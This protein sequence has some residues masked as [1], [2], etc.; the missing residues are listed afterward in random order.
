[1][2]P[3]ILEENK[4][5]VLIAELATGHVFKKDLTLFLNGR[6]ENDVFQVFETIQSAKNF[7]LDFIAKAP[8]FECS[9]FDNRREPL[10]TFDKHGERN[11]T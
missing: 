7:A 11:I 8:D 9:I 10:A 5:S 6:H 2:N 4:C 1:M 3:P